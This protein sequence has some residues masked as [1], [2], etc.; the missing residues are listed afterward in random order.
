P[1]AFGG[2]RHRHHLR[3]SKHL[4]KTLVLNEVKGAIV[5]VVNVW[6]ENWAAVGK[7]EFVTSKGWNSSRIGG[8]RVIKI[9]ARV[10]SRVAYKLED[11]SVKSVDAAASDDV[12]EPRTAA[13]DLSRHPSRTGLQLLHRIHIEIRKRRPTHL[14]IADVRAIHGKCCFHAA[15]SIN[16]ELLGEICR[17]IGVGHGARC[18]QK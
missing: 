8:R 14:R 4:A 11:R 17:P 2:S 3:S 5:A 12:G 18:K 9:I 13:A 16:G 7:A 1:S 10:E 15:L 6:N